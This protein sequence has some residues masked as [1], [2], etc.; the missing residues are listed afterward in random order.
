MFPYL[1]LLA[2]QGKQDYAGIGSWNPKLD[3]TLI[4]ERLISHDLEAQLVSV[5]LQGFFL[6]PNGD[7]HKFDASDH[8]ATSIRFCHAGIPTGRSYGSYHYSG[9]M[10][11]VNMHASVELDGYIVDVLMRD[12]VGHDK[13]PS[14]FLVYLFLTVQTEREMRRGVAASFATIA[15]ATGLSKTSV[16]SA[17]RHLNRRKL[18]SVSKTAPTAVPVYRL[19]RH[20][21]PRLRS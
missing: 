16:Q 10:T 21:R 9:K 11:G 13:M 1:I 18:I 20:W 12:L 8:L 4:P 3:P 15:A 2:R 6:I 5:E 17:I 14:A 7:T 19:N